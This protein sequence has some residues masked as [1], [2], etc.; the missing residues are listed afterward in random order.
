VH[1]RKLD[2]NMM[3][4]NRVLKVNETTRQSMDVQ[5]QVLLDR[6]GLLHQVI[7]FIKNESINL[8]IMATT[9]HSIIDYEPLNILRV[10]EGTCFGHVMSRDCQYATNDENV[11]VRLR[12]VSVKKVQ[13][14]LQKTISW[15][16]RF[17]KGGHEWERAC[18]KSGMRHQELKTFMKTRF[19]YK[20]IMFEKTF[21]FKNAIIRCYGR[22]KSI[23]L[24]QIIPKAQ[25]CTIAKV[26]TST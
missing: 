20:V 5:L 23:T 14:G 11:F 26:I 22:Q 7:A 21:D 25:V 17:E 12:N 24:K 16:K 6:F 2:N 8:S 15:T 13:S 1:S 3:R 18:F 4:E 19:T 10:Y 9:L